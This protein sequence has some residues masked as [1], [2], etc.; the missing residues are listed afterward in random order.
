MSRTGWVVAGLAVHALAVGAAFVAGRVVHPSPGRGF[1]DLVAVVVTFLVVEVLGAVAALV[2]GGV[3][4]ARNRRDA[5]LALVAGW[6]A[7][8]VVTVLV[9]WLLRR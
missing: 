6:L 3:L 8:L 1:D 5:G 7:G 4:F 2:G 9:G